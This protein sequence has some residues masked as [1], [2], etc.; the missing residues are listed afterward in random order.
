MFLRRSTA[1]LAASVMLSVATASTAFADD[2]SPSEKGS[3]ELPKGLYGE[4]DP[5]ADGVWR[6][7]LALLAQEAAGATPAKQAVNWLAEQQCDDGS[8]APYRA[9]SDESCDPKKTPVDTNATGMAVQALAAVGGRSDAVAKSVDWLTSVQNDDGG[10]GYDK[11]GRSDANSTSV[12]IGALVAAGEKPSDITKD[13]SSPYDA[14]LSL[15][16]DCDADKDERGAFAYQPEDGELAANE[17]ATAAATL[18]ALG[19]GTLVEPAEGRK[20]T[21]PEPLECGSKD[22]DANGDEGGKG[23]GDKADEGEKG[24]RSPRAAAEAGAAY[25]S[26]ELKR[27]DGHLTS[28]MPGSED[29]PDH[30]NTADAVIALAAGGHTKQAANSLKWL[31]QNLSDWDKAKDDPGSIALLMLAVNST[32]GDAAKLGS[33]KLLERLNATG[34]EPEAM[35]AAGEDGED[36]EG[37]GSSAVATWS[38]VGAGLAA[39]AGIG[40]MMS[41]R[42]KRL[43][44]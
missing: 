31:E 14:L 41:G 16:L 17:D 30:G 42:R 38:L 18:A 26:D 28:A 5:K 33:T 3:A 39:G 1:V 22:E 24:E 15:Q 36:G 2:P 12:V 6:Q 44:Q 7:S 23:D 40:F 11:G 4:G 29:Q 32:G 13:G 21:T 43:G 27:N 19:K 37:G 34:P 35:P 20:D 9:K 10:W 25:L 8:F